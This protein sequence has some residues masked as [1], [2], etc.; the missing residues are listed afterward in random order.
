M[1]VAVNAAIVLA[2]LFVLQLAVLDAGP[3]TDAWE[4]WRGRLAAWASL[5]SSRSFALAVVVGGG[6]RLLWV[7]WA[8]VSPTG[9]QDPL[10]YLQIAADFGDGIMPRFGGLD[11]SAYWPPGYPAI[12][13]PFVWVADRTGWISP[14]FTASLVNV[15]AGTATVYLSGRLADFWFGRSARAVAA[16]LV[17]LCPAIVYFTATAH[18]ETVFTTMLLGLILLSSTAAREPSTGRWVLIGLLFAAA[19]LVR[20]PALIALPLPA[21]ALRVEHGS[22]AGAM[23]ATA[24]VLAA[25]CLLL[26]PWT[27]RN[28]TQVGVW[29]PGSTNNAAAA[30]FGHNDGVVAKWEASLADAEL[31]QECF[32]GSPYDDERFLEIYREAGALPEGVEIGEPDEPTWYRETL[33]D[34]MAW[35]ITHP[36]DE[37][38][39][40]TQKV[41]Q[42]W[43]EERRAVDLARN[44]A[45]PGWAGRWHSTLELLA[46]VWLWL[47]GG[48]A[49]LGLLLM[50]SC[51]RAV[52]V[53]LPIASLTLAIAA[54]VAEPHYRYPVVPL[55]AVLGAAMA[56][57]AGVERRWG[58]RL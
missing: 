24:L 42:T 31:Q 7:I 25:S 52:P 37:V 11:H 50:S 8:S 1:A 9:S 55:V 58:R 4:R 18:S 36:V 27:I 21:V 56:H 12:L 17:A 29:T 38:R 15:A 2:A 19:F 6:L 53:W 13:A 30:C 34:A 39:L 51:R 46:D 48:L 35:A 40:S 41:W 14:A 23:K 3:L 10:F 47:I 26:V 43:R 5:F 49:L 32:G 28:G 54:G 16:W 33:F 45:D 44:N 22:W 20:S 57:R